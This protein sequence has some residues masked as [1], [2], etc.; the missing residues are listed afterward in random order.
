MFKGLG[1]ISIIGCL[2]LSACQST[3]VKQTQTQKKTDL[4]KAAAFNVQLGMGYLKQGDRPRA[5]KK[6]LTALEQAPQSPDVNAGMAYFYEQAG[7]LDQAKKYY[8]KATSLSSNAG[9]QLNNFGTFYCR[10]GDY[11]KAE[12]YFLKAVKD[13]KYLNTAG[14]YEN[15]GLCALGEPDEKKAKHFFAMALRHDP[16]KRASLYELV[17]IES[18]E[19][20][21]GEALKQMRDHADL[22][23]NDK[24]FLSLAKQIA[25][26]SGDAKLAAEYE[27]ADATLVANNDNSG[28]TNEYNNSNG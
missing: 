10:Q 11:K 25:A 12:E 18:H 14:A 13:P 21:D 20:H 4:T 7:E 19:G 3:N 24:V 17:K 22:V 27:Q 2:L 1:F 15:A 26:R 28:V 8:T 23:L 9:A 5:K 6:L 16:S